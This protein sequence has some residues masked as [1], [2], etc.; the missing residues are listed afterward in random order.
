MSW[1]EQ[2]PPGCFFTHDLD[3]AVA[4]A[5]GERIEP[6]NGRALRQDAQQ[7]AR[8]EARRSR[9]RS[10]AARAGRE[11]AQS[12]GSPSAPAPRR[13]SR[14]ARSSVSGCDAG[15]DGL[16]IELQLNAH[17]RA[18]APGPSGRSPAATGGPP[19]R[20]AEAGPNPSP[21]PRARPPSAKAQQAG[22][23][24]SPKPSTARGTAGG[25]RQR[26]KAI[27]E[28]LGRG[29]RIA[30]AIGR[31]Q[32]DD[33]RG[34]GV[35]GG[36]E[37]RHRGG[38]DR[39][40]RLRQRG[41][42][43]RGK[44]PGA[45]ALAA[46]EH[47]RRR[48]GPAATLPRIRGRPRRPA[49]H[50]TTPVPAHH[51]HAQRHQARAPARAPRRPG[52][53]G[54]CR[55]FPR[56]APSRRIG[57]GEQRAGALVE[58]SDAAIGLQGEDIGRI[59]GIGK[60]QLAQRRTRACARAGPSQPRAT[61]VSPLTAAGRAARRLHRAGGRRS[62][63]SSRA[64]WPRTA[65]ARRRRRGR[66]RHA[67]ARRAA[68]AA[69]RTSAASRRPAARRAPAPDSDS[70]SIAAAPAA[71]AIR[72]ASPRK[73][74]RC[75]LVSQRRPGCVSAEATPSPVAGS[76]DGGSGRAAVEPVGGDPA[77][78]RAPDLL[79]ARIGGLDARRRAPPRSARPPPA[80][81]ATRSAAGKTDSMAPLSASTA[82][83][84]RAISP[85]QRWSARIMRISSSH[86]VGEAGD[87][88]TARAWPGPRLRS[89]A[90]RR[91]RSGCRACPRRPRRR[92]ACSPR[93]TAH[94]RGRA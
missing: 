25:C 39:L 29:R 71:I 53:C 74:D 4:A 41:M 55:S 56:P 8:R 61:P 48:P 16:V 27:E 68:R 19:C 72:P 90:A 62:R 38:M 2:R 69:A 36:I 14:G 20:R 11:A 83:R 32:D 31:G 85:G 60:G 67:A 75:R 47:D 40:A 82:T 65:R 33:A 84:A 78:R 10:G 51:R 5:R 1:P 86:V 30:V 57:P 52:R 80:A 49:S 63:R 89:S 34:A 42:Q 18:E 23:L 59:A 13:H 93:R 46:D 6:G 88:A 37:G 28:A 70:T 54:A 26:G 22:K 9:A 12:A 17:G 44:A 87:V 81:A 94:P 79:D 7:V 24:R 35:A 73:S 45:A 3:E 58:V 92:A 43:R 77:R 50:T 66:S 15:R 91:S 76:I 21:P 64:R